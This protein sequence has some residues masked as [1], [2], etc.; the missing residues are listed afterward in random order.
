MSVR[1]GMLFEFEELSYK[2]ILGQNGKF[3]VVADFKVIGSPIKLSDTPVEYRH[4]PPQLGEHTEQVL[5]EF[6]SPEQLQ[7][8]HAAGVIDS[9]A[10][11]V[12][13]VA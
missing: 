2:I 7:Q 12:A 4:A 11:H 1:K 8:L 3:Y 13:T 9:L 5:S 10:T 6:Y